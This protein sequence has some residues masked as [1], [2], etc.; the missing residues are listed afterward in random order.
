M[1]ENQ[2]HTGVAE[3]LTKAARRSA[4]G[5]YLDRSVADLKAVYDGHFGN[6]ENKDVDSADTLE[7]EAVEREPD[8]ANEDT[9]T[10]L[11]ARRHWIAENRFNLGRVADGAAPANPRLRVLELP[12]RHL[13]QASDTP[14]VLVLDRCTDELATNVEDHATHWRETTGA[15]AILVF[16]EA[17]DLD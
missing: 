13:G 2:E 16:A 17:I 8:A 1:T 7:E 11:A 10:E 4:L 9:A 6:T 5:E 14:F 15:Q 12:M 3:P